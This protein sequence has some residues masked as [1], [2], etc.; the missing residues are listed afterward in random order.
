MARKGA[1]HESNSDTFFFGGGGGRWGDWPGKTFMWWIHVVTT[2]CWSAINNAHTKQTGQVG[3][4]KNFRWVYAC[5]FTRYRIYGTLL[6]YIHA[7]SM[8]VSTISCGILCTANEGSVRIQ[9]KCLV[10]I[11]VFPEMK[12]LFSKTE[13]QYNVLS[14]SSYIHI[15][16]GDLYFSRIGLPILLQGNMWT[17][18]NI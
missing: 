8:C 6:Y 11:Y 18:R 9:F 5:T 7:N 15:S 13:L 10:P 2:Q 16:L 14:P 17:D 3:L 1:S 12:L 4:S